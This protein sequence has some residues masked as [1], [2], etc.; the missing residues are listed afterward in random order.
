MEPA[1]LRVVD[2]SWFET[3]MA[4]AMTLSVR[5]GMR[6]LGAGLAGGIFGLIYAGAACAAEPI[7]TKSYIFEVT[8]Y[9]GTRLGETSDQAQA[10][11]MVEV[12]PGQTKEQKV[13]DRLKDIGVR[14]GAELGDR[15]RWYVFAAAS[16]RAIGMN[17]RRDPDGL[18][19]NYGWSSDP[20][21][22]AGDVQ[23]GVGWR[24]GSTQTSL[25]YMH[26]QFRPASAMQ[27]VDY[28]NKDDMVALSFSVKPGR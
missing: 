3:C 1:K 2:P 13:Q 8:P 23:A 14:D 19:R 25:G 12:G 6:P 5:Q 16:G 17:V 21:A 20:A 10:G 26:R 7:E 27:N 18:I 28:D 22:L 4:R 9:T 15:S 24:R 11:A